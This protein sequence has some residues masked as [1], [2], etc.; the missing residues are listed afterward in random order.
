MKYT[1][2]ILI[3]Q[4]SGSIGGETA[5]RNRFGPYLRNRAIP[6]N[7]N[8]A[9]QVAARGRLADASQLWGTLTADQQNAWNT[10][11]DNNPIVD[12]LG[13][14]QN[15]TGH[16]QCVKNNTIKLINEVAM[17]TLPILQTVT[18]ALLTLAVEA[19]IG[20]G[21]TEINFTPTPVETWERVWVWAA[22]VDSPGVSY[23]ENLYKL[24][25]TGTLEDA[26]PID[27]EAAVEARFG[28]LIVGQTLHVKVLICNENTSKLSAPLKASSIVSTT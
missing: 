16:L 18:T 5:S 24:V 21:D 12:A 11:A 3:G 23:V 15:L 25:H 2:G 28:E 27:I 20:A 6:T 14:A 4:A 13:Q 22:V 7:P 10:A 17:S 8:T 9:E 19:D 1:A 26:S